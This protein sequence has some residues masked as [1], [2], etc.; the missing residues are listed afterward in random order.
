M[1]LQDY[2]TTQQFEAQVVSSKPLTSES[3]PA[4]VREIILEVN[5]PGFTLEVGQNIGVLAPG[6]KEFGQDHHFRLYSIADVP[7]RE[8]NGALL[9]PIAVRRCNYIDEYSGEEYQGV[10]SNYLCDLRAG[11]TLTL[12][13]PYGI[14]FELPDDPEA[15][16][17]L[18]GAGTGIAPFRAF[19]KHLY[20]EQPDFQGRI[21]LFHGGQTGLDLLYQNEEINDFALYYDRDTFDAVSALSD[22][23]HWTGEIDWAGAIESRGKEIRQLL[24]NPH[25]QVYVAGLKSI[26][27]ELDTVFTTIAGSEEKWTRRKAELQAGKR[28][29]EL[30][31]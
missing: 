23:P 2:D 27:E 13:G 21:F 18:I 6:Q 7:V 1:Q 28:W 9:F 3:A 11:D 15:A 24:T 25:T 29:V 17:I 30:V 26:L 31:Y 14:A 19:V 16:L 22:R 10:A 20:Q 12:T 4:E 8:S 5:Q